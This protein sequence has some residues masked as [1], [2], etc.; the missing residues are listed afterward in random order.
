MILSNVV[1]PEF[2]SIGSY[3][4]AYL[5][6]V[7]LARAGLSELACLKVFPRPILGCSARQNCGRTGTI[8]IFDGTGMGEAHT[9]HHPD[10]GWYWHAAG[11]LC[12]ERTR[13]SFLFFF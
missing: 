8:V 1:M 7:A 4:L 3:E 2:S 9:V 11:A 6:L 10:P 12:T 13:H 5:L